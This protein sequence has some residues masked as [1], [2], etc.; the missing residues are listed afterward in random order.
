MTQFCVRIDPCMCM[1]WLIDDA[2]IDLLTLAP[3]NDDALSWSLTGVTKLISLC[4][5]AHSRSW[6]DECLCV[7]W[8][9]SVCDMCLL[10]VWHDS[11]MTCSLIFRHLPQNR[12]AWTLCI[13]AIL[14]LYIYMYICI[15]IYIYKYVLIYISTRS[16]VHS[17]DSSTSFGRNSLAHHSMGWLRLVGSSKL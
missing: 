7:T 15:Y 6:H 5:M 8:L 13:L 11:F 3:S 4:H 1:T 9:V 14:A 16:A 12:C 10:C 2:C 17:S